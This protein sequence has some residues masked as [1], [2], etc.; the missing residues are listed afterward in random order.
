MITLPYGGQFD[1]MELIRFIRASGRDFIIQG[2]QFARYGDHSKPHSLDY[3][4]RQFATNPDTKQA[5]N[6]ILI[7]LI[8]TGRFKKV[9]GLLCPDSGRC[10]KGLMLT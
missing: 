1:E 7:D 8:A 10:C 9:Y 5:E 4:L 3:W 6:S 2:Q